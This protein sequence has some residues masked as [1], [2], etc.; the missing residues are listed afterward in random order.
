MSNFEWF[1]DII[2]QEIVKE[3]E[4]AVTLMEIVMN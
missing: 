1:I 3:W 4:E 2:D